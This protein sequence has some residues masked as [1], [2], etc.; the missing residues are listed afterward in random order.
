M[1]TKRILIGI[2]LLALGLLAGRFLLPTA[3]NAKPDAHAETHKAKEAPMIWTC[4]MHPQIQQPA[5]GDCPIC[6]MD[7][8]PLTNDSNEDAGPRELSMSESSKALADIQ[9][10]PVVREHPTHSVRLVGQL[11]RAE[12]KV[13]SLTARFPARIESLAVD[14]VGI[15][16]EQGQTLAQ[17]YSPE[18]LSAQRE[19]LAAHQRAPEGRFT[20]AAHEKLLQWDLQSEQIA[21]MLANGSAEETFELRSPIDGVVVAKNVNQGDYV[22]TGQTLYTIVDLS[23]LWLELEAYESDLPWLKIGQPVEF[24]TQANAGQ[25]FQGD[26]Q[27]IEPEINSKTRTVPVRVLVPN[28]ENRLKPGMFARA[29]VKAMHHGEGTPLLVP[30]SAVLRTGQRAVVYVEV[31][32]QERPTY[33]GREITLG[34]KAGDQFIVHSGLEEGDQV[35][36]NGAF[37]IDSALQIQAKPSMMSIQSDNQ[38]AAAN[39]N[40]SWLDL[41][42]P[43]LQLQNALAQDDLEA[44]KQALKDMMSVA[45]HSGEAAKLIHTML[46]AESLDAI[47]RPHFETLSK[48]IIKAA[49]AHPYQL[50]TPLY[51]MHCPMVYP[52]HGADWLQDNDKLLN[53]YFG[54]M[55]LHC[56]EETVEIKK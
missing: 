17:V 8:I 10:S 1:K 30:A 14:A 32:N 20:Q 45:G 25:T 38:A 19:L 49:E 31:P 22:K 6:G 47:R 2:S 36:T 56:G 28:P 9:T 43:Y 37:K 16:V 52:D 48:H 42:A 3:S 35:V 26:V 7:L 51:K 54:A 12:N 29:T 39:M 53:P 11:A 21:T 44:S 4:S 55:M 34:S 23:E 40:E 33:E 18:L 5:P 50:T 41:I 27:F 24:T 13:K 15:P 46:A